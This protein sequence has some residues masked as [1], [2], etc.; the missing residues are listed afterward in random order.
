VVARLWPALQSAPL[1][2]ESLVLIAEQYGFMLQ[3]LGIQTDK[4]NS[5][6]GTLTG[7]ELK[8]S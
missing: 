5:G 4:F 1:D 8:P 3:R 7:L 2:Q 6:T